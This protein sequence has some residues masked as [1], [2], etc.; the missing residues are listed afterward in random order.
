MAGLLGQQ[1]VRTSQLTLQP[2]QCPAR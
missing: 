1:L 2:N